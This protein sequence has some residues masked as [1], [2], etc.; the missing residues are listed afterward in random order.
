VI[1][2]A[3][4]QKK[5]EGRGGPLGAAAPRREVSRV[6]VG[7]QHGHAADR[8]TLLQGCSNGLK[9]VFDRNP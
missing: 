2:T 1:T 4:L 5:G 8:A 9:S 7:N 6:V 3:R